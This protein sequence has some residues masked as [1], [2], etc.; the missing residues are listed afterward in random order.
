MGKRIIYMGTP[1]FSVPPLK[2]LVES[3]FDVVLAVTQPDRPKGRGKKM[4]PTPVKEAATAL[5]VEVIQP[6]SVKGDSFYELIKSLEPDYLAVVAFG[7]VLPKRVLDIP[8]GGSVNV[9]ASLL[10][11]YRGPAPIQWAVSNGEKT[12][13]VTTMLMDQKLDT[14]DILLVAETPIGRE[15]TAGDLHD[16][17]SIMGAELLVDTFNGLE[18]GT[19]EPVTQNHEDAVHA[20]MLKK[21]DGRID[22]TKSADKIESF[23]M[24]MSPWPGAFTFFMEKRLKIFKV[25][26]AEVIDGATPGTVI[27]GFENELR[28]CA[29][30]KAISILEIQGASGKRL[31]IEQF[32]MG[33]PVPLGTLLT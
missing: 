31:P 29:G 13:G 25:K 27:K 5:G 18:A 21:S 32:L 15:E 1:D 11:K 4:F 6:E 20:P 28:V 8:P 26:P 17:L 19:V 33:T 10:P 22:W 2:R 23:V 9:H 16:R 30:D 3:G 12:T 24:G 14:G 7:H